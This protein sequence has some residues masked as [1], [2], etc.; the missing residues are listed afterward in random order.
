MNDLESVRGSHCH[1]DTANAQTYSDEPGTQVILD[2]HAWHPGLTTTTNTLSPHA[3]HQTFLC[4]WLGLLALTRC[5]GR[6]GVQPASLSFTP[7]PLR[8]SYIS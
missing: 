8:H 5:R 3:P 4:A 2:R 7:E 6:G 1:M